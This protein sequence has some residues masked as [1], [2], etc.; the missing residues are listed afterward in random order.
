MAIIDEITNKILEENCDLIK[1]LRMCAILANELKNVDFAQW[2]NQELDGYDLKDSVPKYRVVKGELKA[3]N[4]YY[5]WVTIAL[6]ADLAD[7]IETLHLRQPISELLDLYKKGDKTISA[8]VQPKLVEILNENLIEGYA[9]EYRIFLSTSQLAKVIESVKNNILKLMTELKNK[10]IELPSS[11]VTREVESKD[12]PN[13]V[14]NIYNSQVILNENS[15]NII[16]DEKKIS[17]NIVHIEEM[18]NDSNEL[19][20]NDKTNAITIIDT[21]KE[22]IGKKE[23]SKAKRVLEKLLTF[24]LNVGASMLANY[25]CGLLK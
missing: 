20:I 21:A 8:S 23:F 15:I 10:G 4:P 14:N 13:V 2:T 5:G 9:A 17:N 22:H 24:L 12:I 11:A 16:I 19:N 18:I 6:P 3:F 1:V 7:K 25:I